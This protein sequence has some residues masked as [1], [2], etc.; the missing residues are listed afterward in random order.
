MLK[1]LS[2]TFMVRTAVER[3]RLCAIH[4]IVHHFAST[5]VD[6][7]RSMSSTELYRHIDF[8]ST[9]GEQRSEER[10]CNAANDMTY[11][12][13]TTASEA[14]GIVQQGVTTRTVVETKSLGIDKYTVANRDSVPSCEFTCKFGLAPN[15]ERIDT[16]HREQGI[17]R[18]KDIANLLGSQNRDRVVGHRIA[19][20]LDI[21]IID[22][23]AGKS[24]VREILEMSVRTNCV[25]ICRLAA[26]H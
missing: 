20:M 14:S 21:S 15:E 24:Q 8:D 13:A 25:V 2:E 26:N 6:N 19:A 5:S 9:I 7:H 23:R 1:H 16:P 18:L 12:V 11:I 3:V 22:I 17:T 10:Y 4:I